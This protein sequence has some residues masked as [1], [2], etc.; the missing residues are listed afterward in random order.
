MPLVP[1]G[2]LAD[3]QHT[4]EQARVQDAHVQ[5]ARGIAQFIFATAQPN[6]AILLDAPGQSEVFDYYYKGDLPV[7]PL[8]RQRPIDVAATEAELQGLLK[9]P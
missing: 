1:N 7:Y 2:F 4:R 9:H 6:D 5:L 8:P 3:A